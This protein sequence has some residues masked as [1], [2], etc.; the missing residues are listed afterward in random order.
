MSDIESH[1]PSNEVDLAT[2]SLKK[3]KNL[4]KREAGS[5]YL[6]FC[7]NIS[8]N[9]YIEHT[10]VNSSQG[11]L[12]SLTFFSFFLGGSVHVHILFEAYVV[13]VAV[14]FWPNPRGR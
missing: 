14:C 1:H 9:S 7:Q 5:Y 2:P 4:R 11:A 12:V 3:I 10:R 8:I 13:K 6:I